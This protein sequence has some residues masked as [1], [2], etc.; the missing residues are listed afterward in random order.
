MKKTILERYEKTETGRLIIDVSIPTIEQLYNNFDRTAPYY[1]KEL[2]P[3][4]T[5]YLIESVNEIQNK[6]FVIRITLAY[7]PEDSLKDRIRNSINNYFLY[8]KELEYRALVV[9]LKRSLVLLGAGLV[10]LIFAIIATRNST[11]EWG[12][13]E[14]VLSQGLTVAA[15][16]ALWEATANI[17][18]EWSPHHHN[19]TIF[20]KIIKSPLWFRNI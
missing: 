2:D 20:N 14:E 15:W 10:L 3:E 7:T 13:L 17:F 16:V 8:L 11:E 6:K 12:V 18:L 4:F 5:D 9:M 1:R 19:I